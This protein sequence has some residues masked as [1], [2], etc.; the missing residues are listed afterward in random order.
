LDFF[1]LLGMMVGG[2]MFLVLGELHGRGRE[3]LR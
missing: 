1:L 3:H 2:V